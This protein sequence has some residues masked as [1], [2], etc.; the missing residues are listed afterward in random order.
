[1]TSSVFIPEQVKHKTNFDKTQVIWI[2][3]KRFRAD[4]SNVTADLKVEEEET[5]KKNWLRYHV[6]IE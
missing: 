3:N 5:I 2:G 4:K 1:L 6:N